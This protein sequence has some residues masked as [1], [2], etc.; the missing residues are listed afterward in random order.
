[1]HN[2]PSGG[3]GNNWQDYVNVNDHLPDANDRN[4]DVGVAG[5]SRET[6]VQSEK[7]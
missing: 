7:Y 1:K 5:P 4:K 6:N 2:P 3:G